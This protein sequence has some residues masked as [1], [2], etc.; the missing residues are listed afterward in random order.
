MKNVGL[1]LMLVLWRLW[2]V[3]EEL[4]DR[5]GEGGEMDGL[6]EVHVEPGLAAEPHVLIHA[7]ARQRDALCEG[8]GRSGDERT[9]REGQKKNETC[10][11][12]ER[13]EERRTRRL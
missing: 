9:K 7:V 4:V 2:S 1:Q 10:S 13:G 6:G 12:G 11:S 8:G 3:D 5:G